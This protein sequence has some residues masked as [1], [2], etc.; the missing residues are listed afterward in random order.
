MIL[1]SLLK[2]PLNCVAFSTFALLLT[3]P[4]FAQN[5][6]EKQPR[7]EPRAGRH[8]TSANPDDA[9]EFS[10]QQLPADE[11]TSETTTTTTAPTSGLVIN[12][13]FDSS[14]TNSSNFAAI[15]ATINRAITLIQPLFS[16]SVTVRILFRYASTSPDGTP[17]PTG[18]N[19]QSDYVVYD[20]TWSAFISS[21]SADAKTTN[22]ATA[23]PGLP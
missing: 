15:E 16:D 9:S 5:S 23:V 11:T 1:N 21:L 2:R 20:I 14:I 7:S 3:A 22:D 10:A 12:A 4:A 6:D 18:A 19:A 8:V 17:L 13:T